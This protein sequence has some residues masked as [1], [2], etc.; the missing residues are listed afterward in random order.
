[1]VRLRVVNKSCTLIRLGMYKMGIQCTDHGS[2]GQLQPNSTPIDECATM[3]D[4]L[5][6]SSAQ[7]D[8]QMTM[9]MH[10]FNT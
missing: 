2:Q 3:S 10:V 9:D 8:M 6:K 1:M 7:L 5:E 4:R